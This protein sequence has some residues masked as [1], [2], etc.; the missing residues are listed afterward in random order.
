ME[1]Q[2]LGLAMI[3]QHDQIGPIRQIRPCLRLDSIDDRPLPLHLGMY[4]AG[5]RPRVS[6]NRS[7]SGHL[8][9]KRQAKGHPLKDIYSRNYR[10]S[11]S[12]PIQ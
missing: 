8:G 3:H 7:I 12:F 1:P 2:H 10:K 6:G 5:Q 9:S 11:D 4:E